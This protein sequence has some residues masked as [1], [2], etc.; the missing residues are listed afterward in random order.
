MITAVYFIFMTQTILVSFQP[1]PFCSYRS[2]SCDRFKFS[3]LLIAKLFVWQNHFHLLLFVFLCRIIHMKIN[4]ISGF[5][6]I[7]INFEASSSTWL[8]KALMYVS[9][10]CSAIFCC[11]RF[12]CVRLSGLH[13]LDREVKKKMRTSEEMD[14]KLS[15]SLRLLCASTIIFLNT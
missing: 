11:F 9:F 12:P 1:K 15:H 2:C 5:I 4:E 10:Q 13:V 6:I 14:L 3:F 8:H 7:N